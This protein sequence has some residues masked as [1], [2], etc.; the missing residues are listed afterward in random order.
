MAFSD[1]GGSAQVTQLVSEVYGRG[2]Y[3]Q[4]ER[5]DGKTLLWKTI[6]MVRDRLFSNSDWVWDS[7]YSGVAEWEAVVVADRICWAHWTGATNPYALYPDPV[8]IFGG[9]SVT[10]TAHMIDWVTT[11]VCP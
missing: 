1:Q 3:V 8:D 10:I 5:P 11:E 6:A 9:G 4:W 2:V 7:T